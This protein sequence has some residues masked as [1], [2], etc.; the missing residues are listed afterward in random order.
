[1]ML[2]PYQSIIIISGIR[3]YNS[4]DIQILVKNIYFLWMLYYK[5]ILL[6][7]SKSINFELV[8]IAVRKKKQFALLKLHDAAIAF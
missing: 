2:L 8:A 7:A 6:L 3:F 5:N 1:M 4:V